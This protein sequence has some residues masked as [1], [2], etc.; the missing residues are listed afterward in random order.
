MKLLI[1]VQEGIS[2]DEI[3]QLLQEYFPD[4]NTSIDEVM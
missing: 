3:H 2:K 4:I 1:K